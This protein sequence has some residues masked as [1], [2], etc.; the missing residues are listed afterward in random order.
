VVDSGKFLVLQRREIERISRLFS[1]AF[2]ESTSLMKDALVSPPTTVVSPSPPFETH[3]QGHG[4]RFKVLREAGGILAIG[5]LLA[6]ALLFVAWQWH[7]WQTD[8]MGAEEIVRGQ[9]EALARAV[10]GA[11][12]SHRRL[13]AF[14]DQQIQVALN[15]LVDS[16][17]VLA[18][19]I[20]DKNHRFLLRAGANLPEIPPGDWAK[21]PEGF[22]IQKAFELPP[23]PPEGP[24]RG[25]GFGWGRWFRD[26]MEQEN[27]SHFAN[28]GNFL[29][30]LLLDRSGYDA[31]MRRAA[32]SRLVAV[33]TGL[34]CLAL[35]ALVWGLA[36]RALTAEHE[37]RLAELRAKHYEELGQ[38]A[39]GLAHETRHPLGLIRGW[40]QKIAQSAEPQ[41]PVAREARLV[42]E[43]CDRLAAR[44]TQFLT[45]AKPYRPRWELVHPEPIIQ[46]L[47]TLLEP[48][49]E[50]RAVRCHFER[51]DRPI[52][53]WA[54]PELFR[55][56]LFNLLHNAVK[57]TQPGTSVEVSTR[58]SSNCCT[59]E[60]RDHG[61]GVKPE[62]LPRLFTPY[63]ST[64]PQGSGLGLA[65]VRKVV[66][67]HGWDIQFEPLREG[68]SVF[69]IVIP[70]NNRKPAPTP[71]RPTGSGAG[72]LAPGY[73]EP[74]PD[75][76]G[77]D[78]P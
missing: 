36:T 33:A 6:V 31:Q 58:V 74:A 3:S 9:A 5:F 16:H 62:Q 47:L 14:F 4:G 13:G 1:H 37:R 23:L 49:C 52:A 50:A 67:A 39:A 54:D 29:V 64:D 30:I 76:P 25:R 34:G 18:A 38:A 46:E 19:G 28:G 40:A 44:L 63:F 27:P 70:M 72:T 65:L 42:M 7:E 21:L 12:R 17:D 48:D 22:L 41:S 26:A 75:A 66:E 10:I 43:E 51:P 69:R 15:E 61:P 60:V 8:R 53:F 24:G 59:I 20:A 32:I 73:L 45:F 71:E 57:F 78:G 11:I 77:G 68:G 55:Q 35:L 56:A 2:G